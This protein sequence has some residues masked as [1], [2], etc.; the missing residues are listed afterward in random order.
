MHPV[1]AIGPFSKWGIDFTTCH[2]P[3]AQ[4]HKYIIVA[5]DY[6][7]KWSEAMLTY[8]NDGKTTTLFT[9]NHIIARFGVPKQ[10]VTNHGSHFQ[11]AMMT[12]LSTQLGFRQE[13]SLP[14]Y[15]QANGQVEAVNKTLKTILQRTVN[16]NKSNWHVMLF[17]TLW[18]YRM[19]VKTATGFTP[20]QLVYGTEALFPIECE[21]P[22]LRIAIQLLPQTSVLEARLVEL[23][24]LD[25]TRRDAAIANKAHKHRVKLQYDKSV[26]PRIFSEGDLVFVY[27]QANDALGAGKF[28]MMWHGPYIVKRVLSRG[29]Y[30]LQDFEGGWF[31]EPRNGLY[32]KKYYA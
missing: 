2:P 23:K 13:H 4:G 30:E 24:H 15:P 20:F 11:N 18:A 19:S 5:V 28:V 1:I 31:K 6:F 32:L 16:R 10:L 22:S 8:L 7:T 29:S 9:F 25:E 14:Y 27:D 21:I 17:P 3:S 26:R 12:K